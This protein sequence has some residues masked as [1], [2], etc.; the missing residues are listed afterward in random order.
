M[1]NIN[2]TLNLKKLNSGT[3][4]SLKNFVKFTF[5]IFAFFLIYPVSVSSA[6]TDANLVANPGFENGV[7]PHYPGH[8]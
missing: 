8:L 4:F 2:M 5:V 1:A 3:I 7:Q 6:L